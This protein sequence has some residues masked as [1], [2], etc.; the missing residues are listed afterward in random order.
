[1]IVSSPLRV[2][3]AGRKESSNERED[4]DQCHYMIMPIAYMVSRLTDV[5]E[6]HPVVSFPPEALTAY[7]VLSHRPFKCIISVLDITGRLLA[8]FVHI[9]DHHE[10]LLK[11]FSL[12]IY[13]IWEQGGRSEPTIE[14]AMSLTASLAVAMSLDRQY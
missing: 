2:D 10:V 6:D 11:L 4:E 5:V 1:M 7:C 14:K 3:P 13:S 12:S 9:L 8:R